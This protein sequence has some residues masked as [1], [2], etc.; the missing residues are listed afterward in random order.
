MLK[1]KNNFKSKER[2]F[3]ISADN[4]ADCQ[5][6]N[7]HIFICKQLEKRFSVEIFIA[8]YKFSFYIIPLLIAQYYKVRY[9]AVKRVLYSK[10]VLKL[11]T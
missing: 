1:V 5:N 7:I 9:T 11:E 3:D 6:T 8:V 4:K 2:N 10:R